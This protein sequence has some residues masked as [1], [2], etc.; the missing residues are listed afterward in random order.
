VV[1]RR[2]GAV[3]EPPPS[4]RKTVAHGVTCPD[5]FDREPWGNQPPPRP[6]PARGESNRGPRQWRN[7]IFPAL[8]AFVLSNDLRGKS[9]TL[10]RVCQPR[11]AGS[12]RPAQ[13]NDGRS[14]H[15]L[16]WLS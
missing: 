16:A 8:Q 12:G 4:P 9:V 10:E 2:V 1:W 11:L 15:T 7:N 3:R 14:P 13:L 5:V 6:S